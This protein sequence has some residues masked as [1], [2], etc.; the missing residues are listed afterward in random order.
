L[1]TNDSTNDEDPINGPKIQ[2]PKSGIRKPRG[3]DIKQ[4]NLLG[5]QAT[6]VNGYIESPNANNFS[7][8]RKNVKTTSDAGLAICV[9][10]ANEGKTQVRWAAVVR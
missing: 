4:S 5:D 6:H 10:F 9:S 2:K 3:S 7:Y 8:N 1:V